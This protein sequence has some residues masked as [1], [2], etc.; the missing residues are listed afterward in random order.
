MVGHVLLVERVVAEPLLPEHVDGQ[1]DRFVALAFV[2]AL[3]GGAV[4]S[5]LSP[6]R[7]FV[8]AACGERERAGGGKRRHPH[9]ARRRSFH[10]PSLH[11]TIV[12]AL[13]RPVAY[14]C[15]SAL[16]PRQEF[17]TKRCP[18]EVATCPGQT[19]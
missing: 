11:R 8:A 17:V 9:E 19:G 5:L 12:G 10:D 7:L 18:A 3:I 6:T 13:S 14:E 15:G 1:R 4:V 16:T 2:F